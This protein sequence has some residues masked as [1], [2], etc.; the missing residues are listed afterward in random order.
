[1][2]RLCTNSHSARCLTSHKLT[3]PDSAPYR[4]IYS[5]SS[6]IYSSA[7]LTA[8]KSTFEAHVS[9]VPVACFSSSFSNPHADDVGNLPSLNHTGYMTRRL[10]PLFDELARLHPRTK[11]ATHCM[12]AWRI[13]NGTPTSSVTDSPTRSDGKPRPVKPLSQPLSSPN[14]LVLCGSVSGG[15]SGAGERLERLL[16]LS[17]SCKSRDVVLVVYRWYGGVRLGSERWK[18]ISHVAKEAMASAAQSDWNLVSITS[19]FYN[20][21][22]FAHTIRLALP[23]LE[24]QSSAS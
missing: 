23:K 7:R 3:R 8:H 2:P 15:E 9:V 16:E 11:R 6:K 5:W 20:K 22:F 13:S 14:P 24:V 19:A 21:F 18:C 10:E 1:M 12:Y 4:S 17:A